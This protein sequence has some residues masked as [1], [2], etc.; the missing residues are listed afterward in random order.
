MNK[1]T[2][3][4]YWTQQDEE[5]LL[6]E[7]YQA[8]EDIFAGEKSGRK[9]ENRNN[10][11]F[12]EEN[13][14]GADLRA[15][16]KSAPGNAAAQHRDF[17]REIEELMAGHSQLRESLARGETFPREVIHA[18]V[19]EGISLRTAYAEYEARKLREENEK[20]KR[21]NEILRQNG[22]N[23]LRAPVRSATAWGGESPK[24]KDPFLEGF[25]SDY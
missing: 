19:K 6:P 8:D 16:R 10:G 23:A 2:M 12:R 22:R 17:R 24:G 20:I 7:G 21:E 13:S 3:H 9:E 1:N 11:S 18:S 5:T 4:G 14:A 25:D 15:A